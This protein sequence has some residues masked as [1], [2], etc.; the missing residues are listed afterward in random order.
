MSKHEFTTNNTIQMALF[1]EVSE[2]I[3]EES[4]KQKNKSHR[5]P[6]FIPYDNRQIT[7][8]P[9]LEALVPENHIARVV[10]EMI[11]AVPDEVL[12]AHYKGDGK[13]S[14]IPK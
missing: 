7:F 1:P 3:C 13:A 5:S 10:D 4:S 12:F 14:Y 6:I 8:I 2:E 11:E 9:D